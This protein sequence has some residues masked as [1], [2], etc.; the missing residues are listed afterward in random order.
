MNK[1]RQTRLV[2]GFLFLIPFMFAGCKDLLHPEGPSIP[3]PPLGVAVAGLSSSEIRVSWDDA[4]RAD[5]YQVY[6]GTE[7][8]GSSTFGGETGSPF[9]I[10]SELTKETAYYVTV[11]AGN[12]NGWSKAPAP[13]K[14][15]TLK[16]PI[17]TVTI[18]ALT[19]GT[20]KASPP[21][22]VKGTLISL[23]ITPET[24]YRL[25]AGTLK[26]NDSSRHDI[27]G[28]SFT[29]P[30]ANVTV[31]A[32]FESTT[33]P[34]PPKTPSI[35]AGNQQLAVSWTV[36]D[37]A[38]AYE[39]WSGTTNNSASAAK[40]GADITGLS[41]TINSLNNGTT[42]YVWVK[43]KNSAGTSG[44]SPVASGIPR[45]L[46]ENS[47]TIALAPQIDVSLPSQSTDMLQGQSSTFQVT[48]SYTSYQ[49]Y[50]DGSTI[51]GA[52][53]A[54]YTLN[55]AS[56]L[57]RV[58]ELS[59]IVATDANELLSGNCYVN[60][61]E[62]MSVPEGFVGISGATVTGS[63]SSGVFISGRTVTVASFAMAKYET[64]YELWYE[65]RVWA[66]ANGYTFANQGREGNDGTNGAVPTTAKN[67]PVTYVSWRDV[68]VWCNAYSEKSGRV[69]VYTYQGSVIKSSS[70]A[71]ACDSAV[72]DK[73]KSGFR[74]PTE[75][76][77]EF[78]AR[79]GNP[80]D[81]TNWGYT[82][83]GSNTVGDVAWYY[84]NSGSS[85]HPVGEKTA[86]SLGLYDMSG[87]AYEWCWDWYGSVSSSTPTDGNT[88]GS[89]RMLR[90]GVWSNDAGSVEV[91]Y[92]NGSTPSYASS[93]IGFRIVC[94]PSS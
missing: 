68:M 12:R 32:E 2:Y 60:V 47:I 78:A 49:W 82:Y 66:A 5:K 51:S 53:T 13:V 20:I 94:P 14:G 70:N 30:A 21:S 55:T 35:T 16:E 9:I 76:E 86:N 87:N 83:A 19:N 10:I 43:A 18:G 44:F 67:E 6:Y 50:L 15:S 75:V 73:T 89:S 64:T 33:P 29:L 46:V 57:I 56:M 4:P 3:D 58:Y 34:G 28:T 85:T 88:S 63:G 41:T 48:G 8:A 26:Y 91:S 77:W 37:G 93:G 65:V 81:T 61:K 80:S 25:K 17:Y 31:S 84:S 79:G 7:V 22:G 62:P 24:G 71:T 90:G 72:M 69:P 23:T 54:S 40:Y 39:V 38:T 1:H 11:K 45:T 59:V 92:R 36:V 42:Y 27:T 74:L 52:T